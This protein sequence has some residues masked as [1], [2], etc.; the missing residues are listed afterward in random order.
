MQGVANEWNAK[1]I[2][3][4]GVGTMDSR[5]RSFLCRPTM[6]SRLATFIL[7]A[8]LPILLVLAAIVDF[9]L[10]VGGSGTEIGGFNPLVVRTLRL[11]R[12]MRILRLLRGSQSL[13]HCLRTLLISLPQ[14]ANISALLLLLLLLVL[15][16]LLLLL[17][18]LFLLVL[19][20]SQVVCLVCLV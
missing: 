5:P 11:F 20:V 6:W 15:V 1:V 2:R 19:F 9:G 8:R 10:S 17:L 3:A 13:L 7:R 18:L 12:V 14:L 4:F 16:L